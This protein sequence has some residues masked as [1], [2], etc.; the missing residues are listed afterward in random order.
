MAIRGIGPIMTSVIVGAAGDASHYRAVMQRQHQ[1]NDRLG[2]LVNGG[3]F[4]HVGCDARLREWPRLKGFA[5]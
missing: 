5:A 3:E 4:A 2:D 1:R